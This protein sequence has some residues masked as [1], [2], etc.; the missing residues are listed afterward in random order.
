MRVLVLKRRGVCKL[1]KTKSRRN[2]LR[3]RYCGEILYS[4]E[5]LFVLTLFLV[6]VAYFVLRFIGFV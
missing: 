4:K 1:C 3:C 6:F 5:Q 2:S